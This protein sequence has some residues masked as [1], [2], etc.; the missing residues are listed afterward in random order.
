MKFV[1]DF[2]NF[3]AFA[4]L[5]NV[6]DKFLCRFNQVL[7]LV[8]CALSSKKIFYLKFCCTFLFNQVLDSLIHQFLLILYEILDL[9]FRIRLFNCILISVR[10]FKFFL[11]Q[12]LYCS[13][14]GFLVFCAFYLY[15]TFETIT[16]FIT[17]SLYQLF[18][19]TFGFLCLL[20][21]L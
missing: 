12:L 19:L 9:F 20:G 13:E 17:N 6:V 11:N 21:F 16:F 5:L 2:D 15:S 7:N 18:E 14:Y 4:T 8:E 3:I 1:F 10:Q